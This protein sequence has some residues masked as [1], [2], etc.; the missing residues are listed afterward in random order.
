[1]RGNGGAGGGL[2]SSLK[3]G[4]TTVGTAA[5]KGVGLS[6]V[7][8]STP[9]H[10]GTAGSAL[11][12]TKQLSSTT[13]SSPTGKLASGSGGNPVVLSK[14]VEAMMDKCCPMNLATSEGVGAD[15]MTC[16]IIEFVK[17]SQ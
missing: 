9:S 3:S 13:G 6:P 2:G 14:I 12:L 15:N 4:K 10:H 16:I 7:K 1:M 8:K 5:R 17:H 11:S